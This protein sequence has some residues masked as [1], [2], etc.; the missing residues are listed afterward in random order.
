MTEKGAGSSAGREGSVQ[1]GPIQVVTVQPCQ[2]GVKQDSE[3]NDSSEFKDLKELVEDL[4]DK[5]AALAGG[6]DGKDGNELRKPKL[7]TSLGSLLTALILLIYAVVLVFYH[8]DA[9]SEGKKGEEAA[10]EQRE[11]VEAVKGAISQLNYTLGSL[12]GKLD[13]RPTIEQKPTEAPKIDIHMPPTTT[14]PPMRDAIASFYPIPY[15]VPTKEIPEPDKKCEPTPFSS[16]AL[17]IDATWPKLDR[18]QKTSKYPE[19]A[20]VDLIF[21]NTLT[22]KSEGVTKE[23]GCPLQ[24]NELRIYESHT[25]TAWQA[26][27]DVTSAG[28]CSPWHGGRSFESIRGDGSGQPIAM[29]WTILAPDGERNKRKNEQWFLDVCATFGVDDGSG[30]ITKR[31]IYSLDPASSKLLPFQEH[32]FST[33]E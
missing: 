29:N 9:A 30:R 18:Q 21:S 11:E 7:P 22:N 13:A 28:V 2:A 12:A 10:K 24:R 3:K 20:F 4:A 15:P 33:A 19:R 31:K 27:D 8:L 1:S 6:K 32:S 23:T 16:D 5:L 26:P 17:K 14:P 25:M